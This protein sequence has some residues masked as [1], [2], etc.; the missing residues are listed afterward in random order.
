MHKLACMNLGVAK[1][2][3]LAHF[4]L[5]EDEDGK[6]DI[7][8]V[9]VLHARQAMPYEVYK[10][11]KAMVRPDSNDQEEVKEYAQ[12]AGKTCAQRMLLFRK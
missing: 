6:I 12:F 3:D 1:S 9:L 2:H 8:R 7:D 5:P 10:A 11:I 4:L